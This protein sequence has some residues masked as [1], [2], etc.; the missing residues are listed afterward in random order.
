[1]LPMDKYVEPVFSLYQYVI[2]AVINERKVVMYRRPGMITLCGIGMLIVGYT[3]FFPL[4]LICAMLNIFRTTRMLKE[5][6]DVFEK[7]RL[8]EDKEIFGR[9]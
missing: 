7:Q 4:T 5:F 2:D 9:G 3:M 8:K 6:L 1:M